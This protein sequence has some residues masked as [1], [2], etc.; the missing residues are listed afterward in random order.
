MVT[1]KP[2]SE[3][4]EHG[5]PFTFELV[6]RLRAAVAT[7][8]SQNSRFRDGPGDCNVVQATATTSG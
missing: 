8:P 3:K 7:K 1:C 4:R 6:E 5:L 2:V